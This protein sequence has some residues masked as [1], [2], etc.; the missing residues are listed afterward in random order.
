MTRFATDLWLVC[1]YELGEALRTRLF[2]V[3]MVAYLGGI[4]LGNWILVV[5][6]REA[7]ATLAAAL[8]VPATQR[9]GAMVAE[10]VKRGELLE[11]LGPMVGSREAA[12]R[13][14]AEP[15]MALW[16][17]GFAMGLLP[18]VMSFSASGSI[19][20][21]V[22]SRSIRY[23]ACRT[24]RLQIGLGKLAGQLVL[25]GVAAGLGVL[26]TAAMSQLLMVQ[27]PL[28]ALLLSLADRTARACVY[29]LPWAG[30]G[31]AASAIIPNPNGARVVSAFFFVGMHVGSAWI[32]QYVG[33]DFVGRLADLV[34]LFCPNTA[35]ADF[36]S[37]D[38][39]TV[40]A[41]AGRCTILAVAF[42][43]LGHARFGRRDL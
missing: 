28:G 30:A 8:G 38:P 19:A 40:A 27:V 16:A 13:L 11:V 25:G 4:G 22:R 35:W 29:A 31:L 12:T 5:I 3:V 32:G 24:G 41:A 14:L 33:A 7:E 17:A 6:L 10:L 21:E 9:P 39:A 43:A 34:R 20:A 2:Q 18:V 26:L 23:L 36:W 37:A 1:R 42:Y 15:V